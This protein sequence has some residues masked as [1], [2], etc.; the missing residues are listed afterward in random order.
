MNQLLTRLTKCSLLYFSPISLYLC[1]C[2]YLCITFTNILV[3]VS[4]YLG[5]YLLARRAF[6]LEMT[7]SDKAATLSGGVN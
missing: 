3:K 6:D 2:T 5:N 1:F 7:V 4:N